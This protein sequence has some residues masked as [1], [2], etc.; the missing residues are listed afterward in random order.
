M[1]VA[2]AGLALDLTPLH[3]LR[4]LSQARTIT[5]KGVRAAGRIVA[6]AAKARAPKRKGGGA[7]KQSMGMKA[8]KGRRGRSLALAVVGA[9]KKVSK[10]VKVGTKGRT[11]RAVPANYMHLVEGGHKG[12]A[13]PHPFL[14][15]AFSSTKQQ[16]G[17]AAMEV[18]AAEV[19]KVL[20]ANKAKGK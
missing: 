8:I 17:A 13:S 4:K 1:A 19:S 12:G 6:S 20:A 10:L 15:P 18:M 11:I 2:R 9:R 7:L 5:L 3:S 16:A 14:G